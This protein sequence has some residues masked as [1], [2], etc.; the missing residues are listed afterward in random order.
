MPPKRIAQQKTG[1]KKDVD[2]STPYVVDF[3]G[4]SRSSRQTVATPSSRTRRTTEKKGQNLDGKEKR[5]NKAKTSQDERILSLLASIRTEQQS[6]VNSFSKLFQSEMIPSFPLKELPSSF[7]EDAGKKV[8]WIDSNDFKSKPGLLNEALSRFIVDTGLKIQTPLVL[9]VDFLLNKEYTKESVQREREEEFECLTGI[10]AELYKYNWL[11]TNDE[12]VFRRFVRAAV[13]FADMRLYWFDMDTGSTFFISSTSTVTG[14]SFTIPSYITD[15]CPEFDPFPGGLKVPFDDKDPEPIALDEEAG[16]ESGEEDNPEA[17]FKPPKTSPSRT[18]STRTPS[19]SSAAGGSRKLFKKYERDRSIDAPDISQESLSE[20]RK[21]SRKRKEQTNN[22]KKMF[23]V[24]KLFK[25]A[26]RENKSKYKQ[27]AFSFACSERRKFILSHFPIEIPNKPSTLNI[28]FESLRRIRD[29]SIFSDIPREVSGIISSEKSTSPKGLEAHSECMFFGSSDTADP[30]LYYFDFHTH[31]LKT[32]IENA[33]SATAFPSG[34]DVCSSFLNYEKGSIASIV[35]SPEGVYAHWLTPEA[36]TALISFGISERAFS[37]EG[38]AFRNLIEGAMLGVSSK[39]FRSAKT[40][41]GFKKLFAKANF[42]LEGGNIYAEA[43]T[44]QFGISI[45]EEAQRKECLESEIS[46]GFVWCAYKYSPSQ[47][48]AAKEW[49]ARLGVSFTVERLLEFI[50][51]KRAPEKVE[52]FVDAFTKKS[53]TQ[54]DSPLFGASFQSWEEI[55]KQGFFT[56][57]PKDLLEKWIPPYDRFMKI[58]LSTLMKIGT[59]EG[60]EERLVVP[61]DYKKFGNSED[62]EDPFAV[63]FFNKRMV[64]TKWPTACVWLGAYRMF[65]PYAFVSPLNTNGSYTFKDELVTEED[66][67]ENV[68][69]IKDLDRIKDSVFKEFERKQKARNDQTQLDINTLRKTKKCPLKPYKINKK[70]AQILLK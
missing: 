25:K 3:D 5:Y 43:V 18:Y 58:D 26:E 33:N 49:A 51:D 56:G 38:F 41:E 64:S 4:S 34:N 35:I 70:D 30:S 22:L 42:D 62:E 13:S 67:I 50:F 39:L 1:V 66:I 53:G 21:I 2:S 14:K 6:E 16:G 36:Q 61:R 24:E 63:S 44:E 60:G 40:D 47:I 17:I 29:T 23:S 59:A 54:K 69:S 8:I 68:K 55:E 37:S 27:N 12:W 15:A 48:R 11:L 46:R 57:I 31:P 7:K 52:W 65:N 32:A 28:S 19:P 9:K 20:L 10:P 45:C